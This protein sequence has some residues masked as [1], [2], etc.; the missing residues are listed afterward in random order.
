MNSQLLNKSKLNF[1]SAEYLQKINHYCS[2]VHCSYYSTLQLIK[3]IL[4]YRV[5]K[6]ESEIS[7]ELNATN[8]GSHEYTINQVIKHLKANNKDWRS[9]NTDILQLK[10]LRVKA[11]YKDIEIDFDDGKKSIDLAFTT[12]KILMQIA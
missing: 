1:A 7:V 8:E 2:T 12:N 10:K 9:V 3:H 5:G 11:D 4:L 6:S